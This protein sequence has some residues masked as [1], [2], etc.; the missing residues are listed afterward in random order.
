MDMVWK[1]RFNHRSGGILCKIEKNL[2]SVFVRLD[3]EWDFF[4][5]LVVFNKI[6]YILFPDLVLLTAVT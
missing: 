1:L 5:K 6:L 2:T 4:F 3:Y